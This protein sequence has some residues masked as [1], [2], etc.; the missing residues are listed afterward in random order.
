[1]IAAAT[2][3][4]A[5]P[6]AAG[7]AAGKVYA[8]A[9]AL[10]SHLGARAETFAGLAGVGDLVGT[11]VAANSRNRRAGELLAA[12]RPA[13]QIEPA[14]GQAVEGFDALPLLAYAMREHRV[15]APVTAGL[16]DVVEGRADAEVWAEAITAPSGRRRAA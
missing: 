12:G 10:G 6:N 16:A 8:E 5:G 3:A 14:L 9:A 15:A 2:A 11:V 7:A 13:D 1:M 4:A